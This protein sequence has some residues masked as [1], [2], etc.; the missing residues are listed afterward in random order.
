MTDVNQVEATEAATET[1]ENQASAEES[2]KTFSQD[3]LDKIV[4]DRL[5]KQRR[6]F[7][8]KYAGVD[9][10]HYKELVEAEETKQLEAQKARGE[11]EKVL[12][13][14]VEKKDTVISSL[15]RELHNV[16][17]NGTVVNAASTMKAINPQQVSQL[18]SDQVRLGEH[19]EA[20]VIDPKTGQV[21]YNDNGEPLGISEVVAEFMS[22]NP[23]FAQATPGGSDSKS[24]LTPNKAETLDITQL[25]MSKKE[26]RER[27]A[28]YRKTVGL[29]R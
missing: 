6:Q 21:R 11:F 19:G 14:T 5:L 16:K 10:D 15:N 29:S 20:E 28:Q 26:D 12:K 17:V 4:E 3:Q 25:D 27:Y 18:L 8:R 2:V 24:N 7:E 1:V 23:H 13:E 22:A 9:T